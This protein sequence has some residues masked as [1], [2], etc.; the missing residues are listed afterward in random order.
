M[1]D[2]LRGL[3]ATP[4]AEMDARF[5]RAAGRLLNETRLVV[6][7]H[8]CRFL[9]LEFYYYGPNHA[10]PFAHCHEVQRNFGDWYFHRVGSGY[11]NGSF[12][13]LDFTIGGDGA[14]G[15]VLIRSLETDDGTIV[16]GPSL[17]VDH[18]IRSSDCDS[19]KSLDAKVGK[20]PVDDPSSP[21]R[22]ERDA[23]PTTKRDVY[24]SA[25]VG[26]S[27][28]SLAQDSQPEQFIDLLYRFLTKPREIKKGRAQLI[29]GMFREGHSKDEI[30]DLT[31]SPRKSIDK[32]IAALS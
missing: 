1:L 15:G 20:L 14:F 18:L 32:H 5:S 28:A 7:G 17:C 10:D 3:H 21:L 16:C 29:Q 25:R 23:P 13:G 30:R 9:E 24:R 22:L 11:R 31:G 2:D 8:R 26:L 12:K 6:F 27:T 19:V 4:T